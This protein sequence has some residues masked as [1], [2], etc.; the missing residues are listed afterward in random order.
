MTVPGPVTVDDAVR[1]ALD[2]YAGLQAVAEEV[3]DEWMYVQDLAAAHRERLEAIA[4]ED[5]GRPIDLAAA[6][7]ERLEAIAAEDAGRPIHAAVAA[8]ITAA[9][10]EVGRITDPHRAIDWLSTFPSVV[11][12]ALGREP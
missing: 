11:A 8:G 2:A 1:D 12:V 5:A 3:E 4:A 9:C 10:E 6:H 7:R